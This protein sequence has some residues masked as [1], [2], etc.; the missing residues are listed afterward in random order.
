M[1]SSPLKRSGLVLVLFRNEKSYS[2]PVHRRMLSMSR[3]MLPSSKTAARSSGFRVT[4]F[5]YACSFGS[6]I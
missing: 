1:P 2:Y 3:S 6:S 4:R 5:G